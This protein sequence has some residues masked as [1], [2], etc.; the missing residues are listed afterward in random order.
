MQL[1]KMESILDGMRNTVSLNA[2]DVVSIGHQKYSYS[3]M[4]QDIKSLKKNIITILL[5]SLWEKQYREE[6]YMM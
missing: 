2:H 5:I 3:E 1:K 4:V 6:M